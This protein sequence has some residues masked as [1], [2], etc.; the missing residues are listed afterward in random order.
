MGFGHLGRG[1]YPAI[2]C[3]S[4]LSHLFIWKACSVGV[5][6]Y[7]LGGYLWNEISIAA[8]VQLS[9]FDLDVSANMNVWLLLTFIRPARLL[10]SV[11]DII[12]HASQPRTHQLRARPAG[13]MG[14]T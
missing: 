8:S 11:I 9:D 7:I 6:A 10:H 12:N 14:N 5:E 4:H 2:Y 1:L 3:P 13:A